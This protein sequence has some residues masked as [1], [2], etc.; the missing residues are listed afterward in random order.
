MKIE[1]S[2]TGEGTLECVGYD[3]FRCVGKA[4]VSYPKSV[5]I[6][7]NLKGQKENPHYS[8]K[9]SC[10]PYNDAKGRCIMKY[11]IQVVWQW[12]VFIHEWIPGA[13]IASGGESHGCIHLDTGNAERVYNW[14]D[15]VVRLT[16]N[17]PWLAKSLP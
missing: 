14:V 11:S 15:S 1:F 6:N 17:Y 7:P 12:G 3:T 13:S 16:I 5:Y 8:N 4:G 10:A 2:R 9:Y